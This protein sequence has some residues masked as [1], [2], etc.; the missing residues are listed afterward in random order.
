MLLLNPLSVVKP[1]KR[2][3][4]MRALFIKLFFLTLC[5]ILLPSCKGKKERPIPEVSV[6]AVKND[7]VKEIWTL[8]GQTVSDPKVELLVRVKGFLEKRTFK[9]GAFVKKGELLFQ[10]EKDQYKAYVGKADA[11]VAIKKAVLKN[12]VITYNRTK[13]L[14]SKDTVSQAELDK[15][16]ADKDAAIGELD[17]AKSALIEAKLNLS[18]T[19]IIAPIDG[20]IGLASYNVGNMV[21]PS[22]GLLATV[23]SLQPMR[24]EFGVNEADFLRAQQEAVKK[25]VTL[26][27]LLSTLEIRLILSNNTQYDKI[28]EIYFWNNSISSSTGTIQMRAEFDNPEFILNPG[29]YVTV[30][31]QGSIPQKKLIIPQ[32]AIQSALGNKFVMVVDEK[33]IIKTKNVTLGYRFD[34]MIVVKTGLKAGEKVVIDGIQKVQPDDKV[35]VIDYKM[36]NESHQDPTPLPES[37][38]PTPKK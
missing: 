17:A 18:Y 25:K 11:D 31:I 3:R 22:S 34:N 1:K 30:K 27:T 32:K 26:K 2:G 14:R 15:A 20:R 7:D 38:N 37:N 19:D 29:Q 9:E 8:V 23:V 13:L 21:D 16:T 28:G 24:V 36:P 6:V 33:S 12:A 35:K 5:L 4:D 10:I